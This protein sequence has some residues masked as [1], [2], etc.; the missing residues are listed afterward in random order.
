MFTALL[1][2]PDPGRRHLVIALTDGIDNGGIVPSDRLVEMARRSDAV[3]HIAMLSRQPDW[4]M[5]QRR[6]PSLLMNKTDPRGQDRLR[7]IARD[8]GGVSHR[9]LGNTQQ[10]FS[11]IIE[12]F[13]RSYVLHYS[14]TGVTRAGWHDLKV[15]VARSGR[16]TVRARR[17][18]L[19]EQVKPEVR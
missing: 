11:E 9:G 7:Q 8:S 6:A 4:E 1:H 18:Y 10:R 13:R 14:P 3:V 5:V 19:V 16:F 12:D 15:E 2:R 17:G